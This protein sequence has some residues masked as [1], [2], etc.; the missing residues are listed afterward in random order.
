MDEGNGEK[1]EEKEGMPR[2]ARLDAPGTLH[3]VIVRGIEKIRIVDNG[4]DRENFVKRVGNI[5]SET[6][7]IRDARAERALLFPFAE[8][9][10]QTCFQ[11][12]R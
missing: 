4:K 6:S 9:D 5:A 1:E 11:R 7:I 12:L 2:Q 3:H 8:I 10:S